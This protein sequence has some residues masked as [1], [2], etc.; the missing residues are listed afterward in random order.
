M[1][2]VTPA[3]NA[4]RPESGKGGH[5]NQEESPKRIHLGAGGTDR[6]IY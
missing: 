6:R 4:Q 1:S 2:T 3:R 5:E